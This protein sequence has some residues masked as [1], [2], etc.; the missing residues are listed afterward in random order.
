MNLFERLAAFWKHPQ[1]AKATRK[2]KG[3]CLNVGVNVVD[4]DHYDG[5]SGPLR[6]CENDARHMHHMLTQERDYEGMVLLTR[7][8][9][10]HNFFKALS[11]LAGAA[12][13]GD[14]VVVSNSSHGSQV[15]DYDS[16]ESDSMDETICLYDRQILDD[17]LEAAWAT[18]RPGV[19]IM[20]LSDSCHSGTMVRAF[21]Q[22]GVLLQPDS[23]AVPPDVMARTAERNEMEYRQVARAVAKRAPIQAHVL[24]F[25]GCQDNQTSMDGPVNG[26]FT[27]A[28]LQ[29]LRHYPKASYGELITR[30]R[31]SLPPTQTPH[32]VYAGPRLD[33]FERSVAFSI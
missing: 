23:R 5:W 31:R 33:A 12:A 14:I 21:G 9:T 17:E 19:R 2:P 24:S 26:A 8:A 3:Y 32:Y 16:D 10:S 1:P 13:P 22:T 7:N 30:V 20:F 6:G 27:G 4:P 29:T 18:F 28:L 15:F 11:E 25:S